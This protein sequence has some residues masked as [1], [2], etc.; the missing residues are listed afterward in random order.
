MRVCILGCGPAGLLAAHACAGLG[1]EPVIVSRKVKSVIGGA[2]YL[3]IPVPGI[4]R[5][6]P[7]GHVDF[8]KAGKANVY[9]R[10]VYGDG[11]VSTSWD[12]YASGF[13]GI[14]SIREAYDRMW[15]LYQSQIKDDAVGAEELEEIMHHGGYDLVVSSINAQALCYD[16]SHDFT[17]QKVEIVQESYAPNMTII[18]DGT[19]QHEWYRSS[20]IFDVPGTEYSEGM[21]GSN[22]AQVVKKPLANTCDCWEELLKVGRYGK[23]QKKVLAH[24]AYTDT[25]EAL[26][27]MQ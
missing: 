19:E 4:T 17:H 25:L 5:G 18:M 12:D 6:E 26:S 24:E 22:T 13:H 21:S 1:V 2:Q 23:W 16:P 11:T 7:E 20:R 27:A 3:H 10:K 14:W 8:V 15:E 9:A